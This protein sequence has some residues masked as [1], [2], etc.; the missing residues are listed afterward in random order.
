MNDAAPHPYVVL[1]EQS[2]THARR[3]QLIRKIEDWA[4]SWHA[5]PWTRGSEAR[6]IAETA[7]ATSHEWEWIAWYLRNHPHL[8]TSGP[9][10]DT[11]RTTAVEARRANA[12]WLSEQ[13]RQHWHD[14]RHERA[15]DL[16]RQAQTLT[17][18]DP[19]W[20]RAIAKISAEHSPAAVDCN[21]TAPART[22]P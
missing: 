21:A 17:P 12:A 10:T 18:D 16:I 2:M 15:L 4:A 20:A 8:L 22:G 7:N 19:V 1:A 14:G 3:W 11:Q 5:L 6:Y 9:L 13:A